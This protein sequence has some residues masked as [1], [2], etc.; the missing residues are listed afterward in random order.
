MVYNRIKKDIKNQR[1]L[2]LNH[3]KEEFKAIYDGRMALYKGL[4]D[5]VVT[6]DNRTPEEVARFIK[7]M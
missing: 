2:F 1:P 7:C 5:L 6:V 4:A 3:Y